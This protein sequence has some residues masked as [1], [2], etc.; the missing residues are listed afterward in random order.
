M[1]DDFL[2]HNIF[3][4]AGIRMAGKWGRACDAIFD[5][6]PST[7]LST[8]STSNGSWRLARRRTQPHFP[9][10]AATKCAQASVHSLLYAVARVNAFTMVWQLCTRKC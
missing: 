1:D 7:S 9:S 3:T 6:P 10:P 8:L 4:N 5:A 2:F